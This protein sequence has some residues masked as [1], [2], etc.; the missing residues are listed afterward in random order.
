M[1]KTLFRGKREEFIKT[2]LTLYG[3]KREDHYLRV[4]LIQRPTRRRV[5]L[6]L[7]VIGNAHFML[8]P[9]SGDLDRPTIISLYADRFK[10]EGLF[11]EMKSRPG[12]FG[13]H[14]WT[15]SL[16]KRGKGDI[17]GSIQSGE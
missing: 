10:T 1:L 13:R 6:V 9:S 11:G 14:F 12:G 16:E 2:H 17:A 4:D 5:G 8:M 7:A 3:K 15:Y